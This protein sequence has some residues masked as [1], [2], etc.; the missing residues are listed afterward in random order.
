MQQ[1]T[2]PATRAIVVAMVLGILVGLSAQLMDLPTA[3]YQVIFTNG[4]QVVGQIFIGLLKMLVVPIVL[5]SIIAG[6]A[7]IGDLR[8]LGRTGGSALALYLVTSMLA[9]AMAMVVAG[10]L[11]IGH[12]MALP[13]ASLTLPEPPPL[14]QVVLDL[15][16]SNPFAALAKGEM[17]QIIVLATLLGMS[18]AT[19][20][21]LGQR[22][23]TGVEALN[24]VLMRLV[25]VV[26]WWTPVVCFA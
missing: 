16:P 14:R 19:A 8:Q 10:A 12:G 25:S 5:I 9:I 3:W 6:V 15:F 4:L 18:A 2:A 21:P 20:G 1:H 26:M 22:V 24:H 17:I 7:H 11:G 13:A 23:A